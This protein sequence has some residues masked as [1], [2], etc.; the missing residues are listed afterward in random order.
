[1]YSR[2]RLQCQG[3]IYKRPAFSV[4]LTRKWTV[5]TIFFGLALTTLWKFSFC[6]YSLVWYDHFICESLCYLLSLGPSPVPLSLPYASYDSEITNNEFV[7]CGTLRLVFGILLKQFD[8]DKI[9]GDVC[10]RYFLLRTAHLLPNKN[11]WN[12]MLNIYDVCCWKSTGIL[13]TCL[14]I[15][16]KND[17]GFYH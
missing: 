8:N 5:H 1:M 10:Y 15:A 14:T 12:R 13:L 4:F 9:V 16:G 2:H 17:L 7:I 6:I 3:Y 11:I